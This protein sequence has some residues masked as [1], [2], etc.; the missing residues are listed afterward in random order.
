MKLK[1]QNSI[2]KNLL[3]LTGVHKTVNFVNPITKKEDIQ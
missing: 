1:S 2:S 3:M